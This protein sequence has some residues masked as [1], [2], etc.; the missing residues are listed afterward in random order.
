MPITLTLQRAAHESGLSKR[1][2]QHVV[3]TGA[4]RSVLVCG[5]RL[6]PVCALEHFLLAKRSNRSSTRAPSVNHGMSANR[7][8]KLK[9]TIK[10]GS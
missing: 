2:L 4:L 3:A 9:P 1:T 10:E 6:I 8:A 5:R 7:A